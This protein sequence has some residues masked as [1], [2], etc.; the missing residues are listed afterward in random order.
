MHVSEG[1]QSVGLG[2][3]CSY[4]SWDKSGAL[5]PWAILMIFRILG[6]LLIQLVAKAWR[7]AIK[8]KAGDTSGKWT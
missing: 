4:V 8:H 6:N 7:N 5:L 3:C 2:M 1:V